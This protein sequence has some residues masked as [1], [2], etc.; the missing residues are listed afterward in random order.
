LAGVARVSH[1]LRRGTVRQRV[2]AALESR[3]LS[4]RQ[5]YEIQAMVS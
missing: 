4:G 1:T 3:L 5:H 2:R